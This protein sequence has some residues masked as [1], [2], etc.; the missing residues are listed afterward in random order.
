MEPR[1][2]TNPSNHNPNSS[3]CNASNP[4]P[5]FNPVDPRYSAPH[6]NGLSFF[7]EPAL[8]PLEFCLDVLASQKCT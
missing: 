3:N 2:N 7:G 4:R 8:V 6:C 1:L 5:N